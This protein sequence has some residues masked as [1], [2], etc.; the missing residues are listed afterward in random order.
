M[1]VIV[2]ACILTCKLQYTTNVMYIIHRVIYL[3]IYLF[4]AALLR[5]EQQ[6][7]L[8]EAQQQDPWGNSRSWVGY[9]W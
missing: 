7:L 2:A 3:F 5:A 1:V 6:Q 4:I 8:E 9:P